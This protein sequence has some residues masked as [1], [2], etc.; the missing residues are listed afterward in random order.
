[1]HL[2]V[3]EL[4]EYQNARCNDNKNRTISFTQASWSGAFAC[5][6]HTLQ[7]SIPTSVIGTPYKPVYQKIREIILRFQLVCA[8]SERQDPIESAASV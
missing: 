3:N 1:M 7:T 5:D 6:W 4:S 2:L 8:H